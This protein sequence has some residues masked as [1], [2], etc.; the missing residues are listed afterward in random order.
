MRNNPLDQPLACVSG[1][2]S[3]LAPFQSIG[4]DLKISRHNERCGE[5]ARPF[6]THP[7]TLVNRQMDR[8]PASPHRILHR[9]QM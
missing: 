4:E 3:I 9:L 8:S 2:D 1:T 7:L 5:Q 6:L